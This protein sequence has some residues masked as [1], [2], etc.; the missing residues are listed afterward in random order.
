MKNYIAKSGMGWDTSADYIRTQL[1]LAISKGRDGRKYDDQVAMADAFRHLGGALHTLED[2]S[3]HS[4]FIELCLTKFGVDGIYAFVGD[5]CRIDTPRP[6]I[7]VP[8]LVT[9]TFGMLDAL[10]S[11]VGEVDDRAIMVTKGELGALE[12]MMDVG[13]MAFDGIYS[14]LKGSMSLL[15]SMSTNGETL[16]SDLNKVN[17][18]VKEAQKDPSKYK[19]SG[20]NNGPSPIWEAIEPAFR[21]HDSVAKWI[22]DRKDWFANEALSRAAAQVG[23]Y[24]DAFV[25]KTL[26]II[27]EPLI[28]QMRNAVKEG[29][30]TLLEEE[31]KTSEMSNDENKKSEHVLV[32]GSNDSNPSHSVS[33]AFHHKC[34]FLTLLSSLQKTILAMFSIHL[35]C[36]DNPSK[37]AERTIQD[38]LSILHHPYFT[39]GEQFIQTA[40]SECVKSWWESHDEKEQAQLQQ[41]LS[42][43]GVEKDLNN[44]HHLTEAY[45]TGKRRGFADFEDSWPQVVVKPSKELGAAQLVSEVANQMSSIASTIQSEAV[46][47]V[48]NVG[49]AAG[50][51]SSG[52]PVNDETETGEK[53]IKDE[54]ALEKTI[55][56][57][58]S[59]EI[60]ALFHG[61]QQNKVSNDDFMAVLARQTE[62]AT[63][64]A[65]ENSQAQ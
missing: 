20:Q 1:E 10:Q 32:K 29:R 56:R 57:K 58:P 49:A 52:K 7:Q 41:K 14:I 19:L 38:I 60:L 6:G 37:D 2:F 54:A 3:A 36:W 35:P 61:W 9:G 21:L 24:I 33:Y 26:S 17:D 51:I 22:L 16:L 63:Q 46:K 4:N 40:M 34:G 30:V 12:D 42:K 47:A 62:I 18:T 43:E 50:L 23:K 53:S 11:I 15:S 39:D 55:G 13:G 64:D 65:E 44:D 45:F 5:A 48:T 28:K 8:P 31:K 27:I 25:Y 59:P